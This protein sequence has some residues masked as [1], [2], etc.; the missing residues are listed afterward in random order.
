MKDRHYFDSIKFSWEFV[1]THK[2]FWGFGLLAAMLGQMG[3]MEFL[4]KIIKLGSDDVTVKW[5]FLPAFIR[6]SHVFAMGD[7]SASMNA[8]T[9]IALLLVLAIFGF[10]LFAALSSQG[11]LIHAVAQNVRGVKE[12][13]VARAWH[14][15]V[16]HAGRLFWINLFRKAIVLLAGMAVSFMLLWCALELTAINLI[17]TILVFVVAALLGM[18]ATILGIYAGGYVV[19]EEL[20]FG[21]SLVAAWKLFA[22]HW[23]VSIEIGLLILILEFLMVFLAIWGVAMMFLPGVLIWTVSVLT[24]SSTLWVAG[25]TVSMVLSTVYVIILGAVF[26][27]F[28]TGVWTTLFMKMHKEGIASRIMRAFGK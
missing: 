22:S 28:T 20:S 8:I 2:L 13:N 17:L 10:L 18:M 19:V 5:L 27:I 24:L 7:F 3:V 26:T 6:N 14:A 23:L 25:M 12:P 16:G 15:G 1:K 4:T 21:Q 11:A 9:I